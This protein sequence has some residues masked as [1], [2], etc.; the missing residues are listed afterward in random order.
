MMGRVLRRRPKVINS[1]LRNI[2]EDHGQL[3][4]AEVVAF[5]SQPKKEKH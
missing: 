5:I 2:A 4:A 3:A 1:A